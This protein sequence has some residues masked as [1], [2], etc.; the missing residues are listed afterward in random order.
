MSETGVFVTPGVIRSS[1][2]RRDALLE[3]AYLTCLTRRPSET[4]RRHFLAQLP[5]L[6]RETDDAVIEDLYWT[7]FNTPEFSWGH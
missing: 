1:R 6:W 4:E 2:P 5:E 3:N 7:L